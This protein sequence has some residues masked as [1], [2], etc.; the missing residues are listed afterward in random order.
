MQ[1]KPKR[2]IAFRLSRAEEEHYR[3]TARDMAWTLTGL[4][5]YALSVTFPVQK[6]GG[7]R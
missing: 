7:K 5:R 4:I 1:T 6:K 2:A 3:R